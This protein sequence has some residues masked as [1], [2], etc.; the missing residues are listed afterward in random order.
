VRSFLVFPG[1]FRLAL[2][3]LACEPGTHSQVTPHFEG[4][5][6]SNI[7]AG[8]ESVTRSLRESFET[9]LF[10]HPPVLES[11]LV[12]V[13]PVQ[14]GLYFQ[15]DELPSYSAL[16]SDLKLLSTQIPEQKGIESN[17]RLCDR[18]SGHRGF[19]RPGAIWGRGRTPI[20]FSW[21]DSLLKGEEEEAQAS[22]SAGGR[23]YSIARKA[24][25]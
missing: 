7:S 17:I 22:Q 11:F 25:G 13:A 9:V 8:F 18:P 21:R 20:E 23:G 15:I 2:S 3:A 24:S 12:A 19:H 16:S 6:P 10:L 4:V 5:L 14:S 1:E